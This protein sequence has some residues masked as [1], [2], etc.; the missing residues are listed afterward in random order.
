KCPAGH[1]NI[2]YFASAASFTKKESEHLKAPLDAA[3]LFDT[4]DKQYPGMKTKVLSSCAVTVNLEYVDIEDADKDLVIKEGD[5]VGIIPP[6]A[7]PTPSSHPVAVPQEH[8]QQQPY[9]LD[10]EPRDSTD[11]ADHNLED[12]SE[13]EIHESPETLGD[14]DGHEKTSPSKSSD[15]KR[16]RACD[17]CRG[18][19]VRCI[20]DP[21][22]GLPC[23]RCAKAGRQC[24]VTPP[25]RKRQKKA[26]SR[27]AELEK[28]I[29]A[30]TATLKAQNAAAAGEFTNP[31]AEAPHYQANQRLLGEHIDTRVTSQSRLNES[32]VTALPRKKRRIDSDNNSRVGVEMKR[33]WGVTRS[34]ANILKRH[35]HPHPLMR[36]RSRKPVVFDHSDIDG[37]IDVLIDRETA[38][39]LFDRYV[40][41]F[42]G[43]MPAVVFPPGTT[44]KQVRAQKPVL[45]LAIMSSTCY[46]FSIHREAQ[47][48]LQQELRDVFADSIWRNAEKSLELIQ[49]LQVATL[50]YR[51]PSNFEQHMFY[52]IVHMATIMAIDIGM[53]RR[54]HINRRRGPILQPARLLPNA[55]TAEVRR[56]WLTC[57]L[58]CISITMVLRRP[59]LLRFNEYMQECIEY[60][61]TAPDTYPSDTLFCQHVKLAH[62][63]EEIATNFN[64]DDVCSSVS[65]GDRRVIFGIKRFERDLVERIKKDPP[66]PALR[67]SEHVTNLY[68]HEI[69]LHYNQND[70]D[71]RPPYNGDA[72]KAPAQRIISA[73]HVD[74]LSELARSCKAILDS[75]LAYD[76]DS[77]Y[78]LPIIF[79]VRTVYATVVL[80]KLYV[81][82]TTPGEMMSII[83]KD[84]LYVEVYLSRLQQRFQAI[85]DR[86]SQIPHAKFLFVVQRL[87]ER[88]MTILRD[89]EK[90]QTKRQ[91]GVPPPAKMLRSDAPPTQAEGLHLLSAVAM[92]GTPA[93]PNGA[94]NQQTPGIPTPQ[95][96]GQTPQSW[97]PPNEMPGVH[98][99]GMP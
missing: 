88:Y 84:E 47:R 34:L 69:A 25:T 11:S 33:I 40:R 27:V 60:L 29:D 23:K 36:R 19:K 91:S 39:K 86:D 46:G 90:R 13:D 94:P 15:A 55:D 3:K 38:E 6:Q 45:F 12:H 41:D 74:A 96:Q 42:A 58:L 57:Y 31:R 22:S 75:Y 64:L 7:G 70:T 1:F 68:I 49:A 53:G 76:F 35:S 65:M 73:E 5:E 81:A 78:M 77:L 93:A 2:L 62:I 92:G 20:I 63:A 95:S 61:E 56:A 24:I 18:L 50:W 4:L 89:V 9:Y 80:L 52:Q 71:F 82:A 99:H 17:S 85:M 28:K 83:K 54:Q 32:P 14:E 59:I 72:D 30:L 98:P 21:S 37:R 8:A 87:N 26:D 43:Q 51:P 48:Q 67:L 44:A 79:S 66:N 16:P 10:R 97:Y